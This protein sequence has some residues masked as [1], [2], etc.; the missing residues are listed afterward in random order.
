MVGEGF[1]WHSNC[2]H[3]CTP[4]TA[5]QWNAAC[6]VVCHD[7]GE[8][9]LGSNVEAVET[10]THAQIHMYMYALYTREREGG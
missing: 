10:C 5:H 4:T 1:L 6:D 7:I 8:P 2:L 9:E 3:G